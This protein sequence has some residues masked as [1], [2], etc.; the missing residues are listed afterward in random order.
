MRRRGPAVLLAQRGARAMGDLMMHANRWTLDEASRLAVDNTSRGWLRIDGATV[1]GEQQLYLQQPAYGTSYLV[2]K[3]Q[4]DDL[5][6]EVAAATR[7]RVLAAA[8]HGRAP[9]VWDDSRGADPEGD[10]PGTLRS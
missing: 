2:G 7:R 5:M 4:I 9:G 3:V 6:G 8:I 1:W 10:A